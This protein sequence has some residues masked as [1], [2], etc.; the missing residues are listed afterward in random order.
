MLEALPPGRPPRFV[1]PYRLLARLGAG[2]MGEVHLACRADAPTAD[3]H[4]M[5]AVKTVREDL[6]VDGDFR[7]RFRREIAAAR[8]VDGPGVARLV[9]AG[10]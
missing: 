1:G 5:V 3:P 2:G 7:T 9:D 4:R 8:T 10:P 6:E